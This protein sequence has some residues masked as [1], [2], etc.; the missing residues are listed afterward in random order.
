VPAIRGV[1]ALEPGEPIFPEDFESAERTTGVT[2]QSGDALLVRTGRWRWRETHGPWS[3]S[4]GLAGLDASCLTWLH[5]REVA[6]LGSDGVSDVQPSRVDAVPMPIHTVAIVAMGVHLLDNLD[7]DELSE[8][9]TA[10]GRWSFLLAVA[11]LVLHR[12][13]A[14]PVNPIAIL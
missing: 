6:V 10:A 5:E 9:C 3:P 11:P 1:D 7:L 12:G 2:I 14:S 4:D 13:T 8:V